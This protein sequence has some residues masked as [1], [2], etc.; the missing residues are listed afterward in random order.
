M[1]AV[2]GEIDV[3]PPSAGKLMSIEIREAVPGDLPLVA[4][5][6]RELAEY[7]K[8]AHE[9][10]FR[11]LDLQSTLFGEEKCANALLAF[12]DGTPAGFAIYF[13]AYSTFLARPVLYLEDLF[14]RP[15]ERG[16]GVGKALF[17]ELLRIAHQKRC[18]RFEWSVLDWNTS[19][20]GFYEQLGARPQREWVKYR[21]SAE[22]IADLSEKSAGRTSPGAP[23]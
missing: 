5:F 21:L 9:A 6:I 1:G 15:E 2:S 13:Y 18:G 22:Q 12:K 17:G 3:Q 8:L 7:E 16:R 4:G 20:I 14:V 10:T 19:A 23:L 11:I